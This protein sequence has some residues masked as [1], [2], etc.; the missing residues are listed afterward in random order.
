MDEQ[1]LSVM[2]FTNEVH[3]QLC[4]G[5]RI[6]LYGGNVLGRNLMQRGDGI[7]TLY[8]VGPRHRLR[9]AV[10]RIGYKPDW[11]ASV[12][13][14]TSGGSCGGQIAFRT[15]KLHEVVDFVHQEY[16]RVIGLNGV[17]AQ[18]HRSVREILG[19]SHG[20]VLEVLQKMEV[21][22]GMEFADDELRDILNSDEFA[23]QYNKPQSYQEYVATLKLHNRMTAGRRQ[24]AP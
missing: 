15:L 12:S 24:A 14:A 6:T 18:N 3:R 2:D 7:E 22:R 13:S 4:D 9:I 8:W 16:Q 20:M 21:D 10:Y 11:R 19:A 17:A 1:S 23:E 5:S